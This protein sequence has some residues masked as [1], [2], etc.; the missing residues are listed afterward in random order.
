MYKGLGISQNWSTG[1]ASRQPQHV[2]VVV[3]YYNTYDV[4]GGKTSHTAVMVRG[5]RERIK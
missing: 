3:N 2:E 4:V 5:R 1:Q